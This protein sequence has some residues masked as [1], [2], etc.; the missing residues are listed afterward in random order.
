MKKILLFT[1]VLISCNKQPS[2]ILNEYKAPF[3][4]VSKTGSYGVDG[5]CRV[6]LKD[7]TGQYFTLYDCALYADDSVTRGD[8]IR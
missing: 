2:D 4:I 1:F 7:S 6:T 8:T 3:V 5:A